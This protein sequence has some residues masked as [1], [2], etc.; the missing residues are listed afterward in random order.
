MSKI[1]QALDKSREQRAAAVPVADAAS[2][3]H[4]ATPSTG[5][6]PIQRS[7]ALAV[8]ADT[9]LLSTDVL[10]SRHVVHP[11]MSDRD[12]LDG[13]RGLRSTLMRRVNGHANLVCVTSVWTKGHD[14]LVAANLATVI[15]ADE[16][17][18]ALLIDCNFAHPTAN[19]LFDLDEGPGLSDYLA[20]ESIGAAAVIRQAGV[21][22][23]RVITVGKGSPEGDCFLLRRMKDLVAEIRS[24]YDDRLIVM[25]APPI[26]SC[27]DATILAEQSDYVVLSV[28]YGRVTMAEI[29]DAV[30]AVGAQKVAGVIFCEQPRFP[31]M[32]A[33]EI[34]ME[35][36]RQFLHPVELLRRLVGVVKNK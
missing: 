2:G 4:A 24:R 26:G 21:R 30:R 12:V 11:R 17:R 20:D 35:A 1:Q 19:R 10:D 25:S 32:S 6:T 3:T 14:G 33:R 28:P 8:M 27:A 36:L 31:A 22:R 13:Y 23:L 7:H 18:S 16:S 15:A 29:S 5:M 9:R 34:I